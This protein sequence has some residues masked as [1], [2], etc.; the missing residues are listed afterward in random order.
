MKRIT[1][2]AIL[3][4]IITAFAYSQNDWSFLNNIIYNASNSMEEALNEINSIIQSNP[5]NGIYYAGRGV[6]YHNMGMYQEAIEDYTIA[7][8][9]DPERSEQFFYSRAFSFYMLKKYFEVLDD[10]YRVIEFNPGVSKY[11]SLRGMAYLKL[12]MIQE[13]F[14]AFSKAIELEPS[15]YINYTYRGS[16]FF[17]LKMFHESLEDLTKALSINPDLYESLILRGNIYIVQQNPDKA[18]DDLNRALLIAPTNKIA[19]IYYMRGL[20]YTQK[21]DARQF[22]DNINKAIEYDSTVADFFSARAKMYIILADNASRRSVRNEY[23]NRAKRD[24]ASAERLRIMNK[25][26]KE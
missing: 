18:I 5:E 8:D 1:L 15:D 7:I 12:D 11:Y 22:L 17:N 21:G 4:F 13:A 26:K 19:I 16:I 2:A 24:N 6:L 23:L 9:L 3:F 14:I 10:I 25:L 20:A